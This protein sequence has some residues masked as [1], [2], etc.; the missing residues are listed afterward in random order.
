MAAKAAPKRNLSA[1][2]RARQSEKRNMRNRMA[3]SRVRSII[4]TV[5]SAVKEKDREKA[6][7]AL[8]AATKTIMSARSKGVIHKNSASRKV[9]R[10][11]RLVN[12]LSQTS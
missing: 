4:K 9:S 12:T 2:K 7:A 3:T 1:E 8:K 11:S 6:D 5:E 10:L